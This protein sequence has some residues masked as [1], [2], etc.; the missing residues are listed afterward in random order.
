LVRDFLNT[1]SMRRGTDDLSDPGSYRRWLTGTGR[2]APAI[3]RRG[4]RR[5][6]AIRDGLR[7]VVDTHSKPVGL[8]MM[9]V[10]ARAGIEQLPLRLDLSDDG[11]IALAP[12]TPEFED[13]VLAELLCVVAEAAVNGTWQRVKLCQNPTCRWAFYDASPARSAVWCTMRVCGAQQ[14][15]A[16]YRRRRAAHG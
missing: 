4:L 1:V 16:A 13:T 2:E 10:R 7:A 8:S 14:K 11:S 15:A 12:A 9:P 6:L 3:S 5:A